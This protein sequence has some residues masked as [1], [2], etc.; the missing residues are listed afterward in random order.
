MI[1][2][3][4]TTSVKGEGLHTGLCSFHCS[5]LQHILIM[6]SQC[7]MWRAINLC[8]HLLRWSWQ[9]IIILLLKIG[10]SNYAIS[11]VN[12]QIVPKLNEGCLKELE[13]ESSTLID[14][15]NDTTTSCNDMDNQFVVVL[16]L[17]TSEHGRF[18]PFM[19]FVFYLLIYIYSKKRL[20]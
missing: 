8:G 3:I 14:V 1:V 12:P 6:K 20:S 10:R 13:L 2:L 17:G 18:V 5:D 9:T 16:I 4:L 11:I 19:P 7:L 15:R